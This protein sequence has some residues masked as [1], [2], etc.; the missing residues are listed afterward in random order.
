MSIQNEIQEFLSEVLPGT[1]LTN[2]DLEDYF[3]QQNQ[4]T[5]DIRL[6]LPNENRFIYVSNSEFLDLQETDLE[7]EYAP[8]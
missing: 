1:E 5:Q 6:Y 4:E 2:E 7:F 8:F 3:C